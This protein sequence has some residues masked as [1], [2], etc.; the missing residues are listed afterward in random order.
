MDLFINFLDKIMYIMLFLS[1][2]N[3]LREFFFLIQAF[4]GDTKLILSKGRIRLLGLS[5]S[6]ILTVIF[7]GIT[8]YKFQL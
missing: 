8:L 5:L 2:L 3:V 1:S 6:Y 7:T 4:I